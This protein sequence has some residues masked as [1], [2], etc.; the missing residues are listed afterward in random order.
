MTAA[1]DD[2]LDDEPCVL[3][4]NSLGGAVAAEY[5][6]RRPE[7]VQALVLL[8]PAGA[9]SSPEE[10]DELRRAFDL[11][12]RRDALAF[13]ARVQHRA[14]PAM[15][16]VAHDLPH[17]MRRRAVR[18]VLASATTAGSIDPAALARL[19]MPILLWW[20]SSERI[21]PASHLAWYR[22]NLPAH[23]VIERPASATARSSTTRPRSTRGSARCS[24]R[25]EVCRGA[26]RS[27]PGAKA[28]EIAA[29]RAT[30]L[31]N[32]Q[33][34]RSTRWDLPRNEL[35]RPFRTSA[36]PS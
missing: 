9:A 20:G 21:L 16:L 25:D 22:R 7:Q 36:S 32:P 29:A 34:R 24:R 35:P 28:S 14:P 3:I 15:R 4:G 18:D 12:N 31:R 13:L 8:S 19:P 6:I 1:L 26:S 33:Q 5:A 30:F 11:G 2:L 10:L 17:L 27:I 23:A